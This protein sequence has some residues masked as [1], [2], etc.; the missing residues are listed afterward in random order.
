MRHLEDQHQ[1][2]LF[3]W[4]K[5]YPLK[6]A[7]V[8]PKSRLSDYLIAIPNGGKRN[9]REA[10]RL[11]AMGVHPGVSD[12]FL[13][14][15]NAHYRGMWIELKKPRVAFKTPGAADRAITDKQIDWLE[16][17]GTAGYANR[18]CYGWMEAR[19]EIMQYLA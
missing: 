8:K 15:P 5:M 1:A 13:P 7:D 4:A 11:K 14:L 18:V 12:I 19:D 3:Q 9:V 6:R 16:R 10:V 2:A 17:M